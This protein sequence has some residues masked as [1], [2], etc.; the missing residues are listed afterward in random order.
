MSSLYR[1]PERAVA[2]A[3]L[4]IAGLALCA[5]NEAQSNPAMPEA[6][7]QPLDVPVGG[8]FPNGTS[9]PPLESIAQQY[10][11]NPHAIADGARLFDWYNC[12]GCHFHGAGGIGP[13]FDNDGQWIYG[14]RLDQIYASIYQ[15]RPNGMPMWGNLLA[16]SQ[17]WELAAYVKSLSTQSASE[18]TPTKPVAAAP[19]PASLETEPD[20]ARQSTGAPSPE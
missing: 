16:S 11:N 19:G 4:L 6:Q 10:Q 17:I 7:G 15:G 8:N 1:N 18:A 12:S 3:T 9:Q 20:Q 2:A 13:A 5:C 14:G